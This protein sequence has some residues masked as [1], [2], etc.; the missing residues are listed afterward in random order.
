M[1]F[2]HPAIPEASPFSGKVREQTGNYGAALEAYSRAQYAEGRARKMSQVSFSMKSRG[3]HRSDQGA[4]WMD[5]DDKFSRLAASSPTSAMSDIFEQHTARLEE[6]VR[7]FAP[8]QGQVGMMFAIGGRIIG[9]DLFDCAGTLRKLFPKLIRSCALDALDASLAKESEAKA[10]SS[11]D[12][13][14]F[15]DRVGQARMET[16]PA[17]GEGDDI[18][19]SARDLTGA[20]LAKKERLVHLSAFRLVERV[21]TGLNWNKF[22]RFSRDRGTVRTNVADRKES[23]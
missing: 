2:P 18:R 4:V 3:E 23:A 17:I 22:P 16:F 13:A 1:P 9:F 6:F 10:P 20:A 5:L 7:S 8:A 11:E 12:A 19:I 14:K 21:N 15:L